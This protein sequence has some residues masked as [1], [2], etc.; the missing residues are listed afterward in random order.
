MFLRIRLVKPPGLAVVM[1][2]VFSLTAA[3]R[4][5]CQTSDINNPGLQ[6]QAEFSSV[7]G[8]FLSLKSRLPNDCRD[9]RYK[10]VQVRIKNNSTQVVTIH[11]D[12]AQVDIATQPTLVSSESQ[13]IKKSG[14]GLSYFDKSLL[15]VVGASTVGLAEPILQE[16]LEKDDYPKTAYGQDAIRQMIEGERL[17]R[18]L[19]IPG[20]DTTGWLCVRCPRSQ[21]PITIYIPVQSATESRL[22]TI[23]VASEATNN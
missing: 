11:G 21:K 18:R 16:M 2:C 12:K 8:S 14:C 4:S 7:S 17:G 19:L 13:L 6:G 9:T 23:K 22:V 10:C 5:L 1:A 20:D 3:N 15:L